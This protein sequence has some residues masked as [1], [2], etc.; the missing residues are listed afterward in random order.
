MVNKNIIIYNYKDFVCYMSK[1]ISPSTKSIEQVIQFDSKYFKADPNLFKYKI[2]ALKYTKSNIISKKLYVILKNKSYIQNKYY[3]ELVTFYKLNGFYVKTIFLSDM[4]TSI[5]VDLEDLILV[6]NSVCILA[7]TGETIEKNLNDKKTTIYYIY[8]ILYN[9]DVIKKARILLKCLRKEIFQQNNALKISEPLSDSA[10][11]NYNIAIQN[12]KN[13]IMSHGDCTWYHSVWQYLRII[14]KVSSPEWHVMFYET[15][16]NKL[17]KEKEKPK[18]LISGTA[19]YSLLA[20][21]YNSSMKMDNKAEIFVL[22]TCKTPLKIC[23]WYAENHDFKIMVLNMSILDLSQ[24]DIKFDLICSDAFLTRFSKNDAKTV[25]SNWYDALNKNGMLVT[26][27]RMREYNNFENDDYKN[28]YIMDCVDRF[29][30]WEGYFNIS[31]KSFKQMVKEYVNKMHS[32]DLGNKN[33]IMEMFIDI[34]FV[35]DEI[36]TTNDTPGEL[37]E[38]TYYEICCRKEK[39]NED[40]K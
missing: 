21:V 39:K 12:C 25:V 2:N 13:G 11:I 35:I 5:N 1:T 6:D 27:V 29:K 3:K 4:E 23:E 14:N 33:D 19:D 18:I 36:S 8:N 10:D 22:D 16:F 28:N 30:K 7:K 20:Y 24:L 38:T 34:G 40:G 32:H 9:E 26:T 17:F 37:C 15:C 31:I